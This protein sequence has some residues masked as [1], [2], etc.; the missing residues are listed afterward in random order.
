[1]GNTCHT[2][3]HGLS[4][5]KEKLYTFL[6]KKMSLID[7]V[8]DVRTADGYILRVLVTTFTSRKQGQLKSNSYCQHSQVRA[9]RKAFTKY[10]AKNAANSSVAD[11]ASSVIGESL[12]NKLAERGKKIFP[13]S[14]VLVRKVKVLKKSK[15][16]VNK[17]VSET[18]AKRETANVGGQR[19]GENV[20]AEMEEAKNTIE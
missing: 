3:F 4:M 6:R 2:S 15:V 10:L 13:L 12:A 14:T 1:M 17:L 18:N 11:F 19:G 7:V 8:C 16:D 5:I 20:A 9:I